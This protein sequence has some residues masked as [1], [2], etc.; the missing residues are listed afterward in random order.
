[1]IGGGF[2]GSEIAAAL[3]SQGKE[4]VMIFPEAG[5]GARVLPAQV[6]DFLNSYFRERGVRILDGHLVQSLSPDEHWGQPAHDLG[7]I[8]RVDGVA[9]GLGIRPNIGLAHAAGLEYRRTGSSLTAFC[10]PAQRISLP[11]VM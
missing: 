4:V 11:P 6:S 2:I 3:A 7:E 5:I 1:M 10:A 8:L 9:A